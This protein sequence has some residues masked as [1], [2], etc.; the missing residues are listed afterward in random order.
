MATNIK[1][2]ILKAQPV[3]NAYARDVRKLAS[4]LAYLKNT[5]Y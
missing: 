3:S 4:T 2:L 5:S 1:H